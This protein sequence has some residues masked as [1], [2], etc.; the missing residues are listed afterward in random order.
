[1]PS[2]RPAGGTNPN[3]HTG[4]YQIRLS[5][6][7]RDPEWDAFLENTPGGNHL[8]SS[9]WGQVKA[10]LGWRTVRVVAT[11]EGRIRGGAQVL[12]RRLPLVGSVGY[13]P[14]GPVLDT[15]DA[16]LRTLVLHGIRTVVRRGRVVYLVVQPSVG[17]EAL[18]AELTARGFR[19]A[20]DP[21]RPLPT[22]TL[23]VDLSPD[24]DALLAAMRSGTRYNIRHAE[25][26]GV[27]VRQG[28]APDLATFHRLLAMTGRRQGFPVPSQEYFRHMLDIMAPP[29]H[30]RLFV[31]E[32]AGEPLSAALVIAFAGTVSYKRSAWSG[33]HGRLHPNELLQWTAIRWAKREGYGSFDFEGLELPP[34]PGSAPTVG[35]FQSVSAFKAGFGGNVVRLPQAYERIDNPL[36]RRGYYWL[37]PRLVES[38]PGRRVV[39]ALRNR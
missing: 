17:D 4:G 23:V 14:L 15:D 19:P 2:P 26:K 37:G 12:L 28:G 3:V 38:P 35:R 8:Q 16:V 27:T 29:G 20:R 7:A 30:A 11:R 25:R 1:M 36:L 9:Y 6:A 21:V 5:T 34:A 18:A 39:D 22:A 32:F 31:A 24:E 13:V 33:E 10:I